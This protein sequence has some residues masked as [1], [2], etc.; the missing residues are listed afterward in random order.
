MV[1][2][3][4]NNCKWDAETISE[5]Y[6]ARWRIETFF[7]LIK[8]NLRIKTFVGTN[9]N[10]V[11]TQ[12]WTAMIAILLLQ[13]LRNRSRYNWHMSNLVTFIRIHLMSHIDLWTRLNQMETSGGGGTAVNVV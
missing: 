12:I 5:L 4:T 1:E 7:K 2:L 11:H 8:Q 9:K 10:A 6:P 13:Y 3:D